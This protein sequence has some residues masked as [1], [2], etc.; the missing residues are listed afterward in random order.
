MQSVYFTFDEDTLFYG[1]GINFYTLSCLDT[2]IIQQALLFNSNKDE[3]LQR[4][5]NK[6][7]HGFTLE[8]DSIQELRI[9][10][11]E[12]KAEY[13]TVKCTSD[14]ILTP[15]SVW[16]LLTDYQKGSI[17]K[18][19]PNFWELATILQWLKPLLKE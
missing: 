16:I 10:C 2:S 4:E 8:V 6:N 15:N 5:L 18:V 1:N 9:A 3:K 12:F 7:K 13:I 19:P 14:G 17:K 11:F